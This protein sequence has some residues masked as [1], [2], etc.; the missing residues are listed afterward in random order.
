V[1]TS[2]YYGYTAIVHDGYDYDG[3]VSSLSALREDL[4]V[5]FRFEP[6]GPLV[7]G[8]EGKPV[9]VTRTIGELLSGEEVLG[10]D[11]RLLDIPLGTHVL[12]VTLDVGDGTTIPLVLLSEDGA[13]WAESQT[14]RLAEVCTTTCDI[15]M[16]TLQVG[17]ESAY[18]A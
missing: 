6:V 4:E 8:S 9:V 2:A 7:D 13:S 12:T 3:V 1:G 10:H 18:L 17:I 14:I 5:V 16:A 15:S 11:S